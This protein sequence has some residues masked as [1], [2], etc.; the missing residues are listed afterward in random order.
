M[1]ITDALRFRQ[2][3]YDK[4]DPSA[5]E[6]FMFTEAMGTLIQETKKP[7][8]MAE[9]AWFYCGRK[10]FATEKKYLEMAAECGYGP[11]HEELGYMWFHGQHGEKDYKKAFEY[12][13]K[14]AE[15]DKFGNK[16]SLW[17]RFKLADMYRFGTGVEKDEAKYREMIEQAYKEVQNPQYL[18]EPFPEI[19]YRLAGIRREQGENAEAIAL[20]RRGKRFME[21]R[22]TYDPFWGHI[23]VMGR[24]VR[25]LYKLAPF[26]PKEGNFYDLFHLVQEP[27]Q[28]RV[29]LHGKVYTV[30]VAEE[31][32]ERVVGLDGKWYNRFEDLIQKAVIGGEKVTQIFDEFEIMRPRKKP[33]SSTSSNS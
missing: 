28:Y 26:S 20:L 30:E 32:G 33:E 21:E 6:E 17:C 31:D 22:L 13:S 23:E 3:F 10:Q 25:L 24:I 1:T 11:A 16:G 14:G 19:A 15:P 27:G 7:E 29:K 2:D 8:Y 18:N 12:F 4:Q 5:D 9:L